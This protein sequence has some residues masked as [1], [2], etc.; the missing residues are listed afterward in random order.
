VSFLYER[1]WRESFAQA[2]FPGIEKEYELA[3]DFFQNARGKTVMDLSCGSGSWAIT[4][5]PL[6]TVHSHS[7]V[8]YGS[9]AEIKPSP[10][11]FSCFLLPPRK[12]TRHVCRADGSA[13]GKEQRL[14]QSGGGGF[15]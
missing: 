14:R 7:H 3:M 9:F 5:Q 13:P 10:P 2:G 8:C 12:P 15:Q 6:T 4:T 11:R 1:G